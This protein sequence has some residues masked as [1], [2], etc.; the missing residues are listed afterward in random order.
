MLVIK[1]REDSALDIHYSHAYPIKRHPQDE[2]L[3]VDLSPQNTM[4]THGEEHRIF[5]KLEK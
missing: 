4:F 1:E 5:Q 2:K 3:I